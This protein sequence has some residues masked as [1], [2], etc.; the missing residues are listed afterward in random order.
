MAFLILFLESKI[1]LEVDN[2]AWMTCRLSRCFKRSCNP[3]FDESSGTM[4]KPCVDHQ[5]VITPMISDKGDTVKVGDLIT[6]EGKHGQLLDCI[7]KEGSCSLTQCTQQDE[8]GSSECSNH[9]F[10]ITSEGKKNGDI[11]Q[12]HD[13]VRLEYMHNGSGYYLD[14]TGIKCLVRTTTCNEEIKEGRNNCKVPSFII[15]K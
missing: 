4:E 13:I 12:T 9:V 8:E 3:G 10:H 15:Q 7:G 14:C 1:S 6:L 11:V 5:F 2:G